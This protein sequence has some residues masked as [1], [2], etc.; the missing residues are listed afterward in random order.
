MRKAIVNLSQ[1]TL[2]SWVLGILIILLPLPAV[3]QTTS[4][5]PR[6]AFG[7]GYLDDVSYR[8]EAGQDDYYF[9]LAMMFPLTYENRK[10]RLALTYSPYFERFQEF[11]DLDN[12]GLRFRFE[13]GHQPTQSST[14]NFTAT[15]RRIEDQGDA[16]S[17]DDVDFFLIP[18]SLLE[19]RTA[20]LGYRSRPAAGWGWGINGGYGF[21]TSTPIEAIEEEDPILREEKEQYWANIDVTRALSRSTDLG[22]RY[23]YRRF[24]NE[25]TPEEWVHI[26]DFFVR[27]E[28]AQ[29]LSAEGSLGVFRRERDIVP[30]LTDED[31]YSQGLNVG[32]SISRQFQ[33]TRLR[34][35]AGHSPSGGGFRAGTST[36]TVAS[37]TYSG[38]TGRYFSWS[39]SGRWAYRQPTNELQDTTEAVSLRGFLERR[40]W[41]RVSVAF[42]P[43][44]I[45]QVT[46]EN[47]REGYI[48]RGLFGVVWYPLEKTRLGQG[49]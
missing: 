41:R 32:V 2:R 15:Y 17:L 19:T 8:G 14:I 38:S 22:L 48:L 21:N 9:R 27:R 5:N 40:L 31:R 10:T 23:G 24:F 44:Y 43:E 39:L 28:I 4:F 25:I 34:F 7:A 42:G 36:N 16:E 1:P 18:R 26:V 11:S 20:S 3:A 12:I 46:G 33:Y 13:V 49:I 45:R 29:R 35:F 6:I 30:P 37:L 47:V